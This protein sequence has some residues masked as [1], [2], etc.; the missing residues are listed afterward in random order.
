MKK[1]KLTGLFFLISFVAFAQSDLTTENVILITFDGF[2]WEELFTG[3][4]PELIE[5]KKYVED[6]ESLKS[7]FWKDDALER[8]EIL[9]PFFWNTIAKEGQIYGNRK[10]KNF[11]NI[12]NKQW[13][14]YPGYNEILSGFSDDDRIHSNDKIENPNK[15]VLEFINNQEAY[16]GEVAA[17]GSWDVFP[18]IINEERSGI[19]VNAGF[20]SAT[21][22]DLTDTEKLLNK[23]QAE[24]PS[25]WSSVRLD[26]FTHNYAL[27]YLQKH[28][29]KMLFIS[30]GETDDFAHEGKYDAYLYSAHRTDQFI[31]E[32][33]NWTQSQEQYR[34]KTTFIITTD[35]GRGA[36]DKWKDHG[37]E[38][39]GAGSIWIA[40]MGPDSEALGEV[41]SKGQL[42]QNQVANTVA[43]LLGL[44]YTNEKEVGKSISSAIKKME[45]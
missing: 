30:Y 27:E 37:I 24:V 45:E 34:G 8:R 38:V 23:L 2:R 40:V 22:N 15:T 12:K 19:P 14:S 42:Y 16:K 41:K 33:W 1:L 28:Q 17:F 25:P 18:Y 32:L 7:T 5:N 9:M 39:K 29:P 44:D 21:G 35:H 26:A 3:A 31:K 20:E 43:T 11:V 13:F 6:I 36:I 10:Y 4:D